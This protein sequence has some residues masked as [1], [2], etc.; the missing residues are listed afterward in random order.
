MF[1]EIRTILYAA[2]KARSLELKTVLVSVVALEGSAYRRP[3][4]RMLIREDGLMEGAVSG[5]CVEKEIAR[6]AASVF[7]K[8]TAKLMVY[9]G[10]FRLGCEGQLYILIEPFD[11]DEEFFSS[12]EEFRKARRPLIIRTYYDKR[13]GE[14]GNAGSLFSLSGGKK[15]NRVNQGSKSMVDESGLQCFEQT[16]SPAFRLFVV[17]A[18]HD[19]VQLCRYAAQTGW[20]VTVVAAAD[21]QKDAD[22][23]QGAENFITPSPEEFSNMAFDWQT[24]VVLMTHSYVKDMKFL[25]ALV[26]KELGYLGLLGPRHRRERM[27]NEFMEKDLDLPLEF[28]ET[29][30]GP[31]GINIGA[32]T[33]QEIGI[34]IIAEILS[35]VRGQT[36][37]PLRD[38]NKGIHS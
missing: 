14:Q 29:V 21:E 24:A 34:S 8:D 5:G 19:A 16:I 10:R 25:M 11:P 23:F 7:K 20:E 18:E 15:W 38:K 30:H 36:P 32:E 22:F 37:I 4:V 33:P 17:G 1:H 31:S 13:E 26:D 9:D 2:K 27:L 6:Q 35:V 12:F 3:G 28:F